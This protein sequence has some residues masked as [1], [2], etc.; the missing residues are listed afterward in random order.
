MATKT[1]LYSTRLRVGWNQATLANYLGITRTLL[2][3]AEVGERD[4]PMA[5][6][7]RLLK[8]I[9]LLPTT[10]EAEQPLLAAVK[11]V[12]YISKI[13]NEIRKKTW[14]LSRLQIKVAQAKE[15]LLLLA[16]QKKL[17]EQVMGAPDFNQ[18]ESREKNFWLQRQAEVEQEQVADVYFD[19]LRANW[20]LELLT[21]ELQFL[22]KH[23]A[24]G[25][26]EVG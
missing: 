6:Y 12:P 26:G 14:E 19:W 23:V 5:A 24:L 13:V 18:L 11:N 9:Q 25:S 8:L 1:L 4:L 7:L 2:S 20:T 15:H 21:I 10:H 16:T 3:M 17:Q 22:Q